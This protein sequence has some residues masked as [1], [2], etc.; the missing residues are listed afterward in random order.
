MDTDV[1]SLTTLVRSRVYP[2]LAIEYFL[3]VTDDYAYMIDNLT[4]RYPN[5]KLVLVGFSLGGNLISK[6]LSEDKKR[7]NS[8]IGGISICQGYNAIETDCA[9]EP[10]EREVI[11]AGHGHSSPEESPV[12]RRRFRKN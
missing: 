3:M 4:E 12:R 5:T 7:P 6:Y 9:C 1:L 8:I 10:P 11:T 2:S